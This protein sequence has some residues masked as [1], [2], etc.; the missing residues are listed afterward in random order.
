MCSTASY[1]CEVWVDSKKI[2]VIEVLY[3]R[4]FKYLLGVQKTTSTSIVLV[5]FGKFPF[6]NFAWG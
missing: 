5:E 4:F 6:E 3:Q 2:K 1:T